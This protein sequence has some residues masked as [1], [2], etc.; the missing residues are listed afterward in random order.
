MD[1]TVL[2]AL[3]AHWDKPKMRIVADHSAKEASVYQRLALSA[4]ESTNSNQDEKMSLDQGMYTIHMLSGELKYACLTSAAE[5]ESLAP[6]LASASY[7]FLERLR[8][9]YRELPILA[10][11][12]RDLTNLSIIDLS[13]PLKKIVE[14][15]NHEESHVIPRLEGELV[16]VRRALLDGVQKLVDRD[17]R[18]DDLIRKTQTL[19]IMVRRD[20]RA[21]SRAARRR[22]IVFQ[23]TSV[24]GVTF[25]LSFILV[26]LAYFGIL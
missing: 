14:D 16:D 23:T 21:A 22:K 20:Y 6:Q 5:S 13:A 11:L 1:K 15:Y 17:Q 2:Y 24:V 26:C 4:L 7:I 25:L 9:V 8:S 10:D 19:Q 3:V 12:S 18:L